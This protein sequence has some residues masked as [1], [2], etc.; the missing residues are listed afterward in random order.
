MVL[1]LVV[2]FELYAA[3][4][5]LAVRGL[6]EG[7]ELDHL[8]EIAAE[9]RHHVVLALGR[10]TRRVG[11]QPTIG[12]EQSRVVLAPELP[13]LRQGEILKFFR[14]PLTCAPDA[15]SCQADEFKSWSIPGEGGRSFDAMISGCRVTIT[16]GQCQGAESGR[17]DTSHKLPP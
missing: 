11:D 13:A 5:A 14:G 7:F 17:R 12:K 16:N 2:L 3:D 4:Q 1:E 9:S 15:A 8:H 6:A 10:T